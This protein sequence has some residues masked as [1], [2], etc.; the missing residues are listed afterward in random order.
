MSKTLFIDMDGTLV[1]HN[2]DP[3]NT[4]DEILPGVFEFLS[5]TKEMGCFHVLT[6]NRSKKNCEKILAVFA[7]K[8]SFAFDLELYDLPVGIRI[9]IN[10]NKGSEVRAIAIP[11][12]RDQGLEEVNL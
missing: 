7:D 3:Q 10:D 6:T 4:E 11:L 1:K 9:L 8:I 12:T 2:Y 5:N